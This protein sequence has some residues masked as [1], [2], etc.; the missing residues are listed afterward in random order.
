MNSILKKN[1]QFIV[2]S[3]LL[4]TLVFAAISPVATAQAKAKTDPL[5]FHDAMRKLWED[6]ITFTRLFIVSF[7]GGLPDQGATADRLLQNQVHIGNAI[8]PFY[9][10]AAGDQLTA[11]LRDHILI[12]VEVLDAA[13]NNPS[14]LQVALDRWYANADDIAVFLNGANPENWPLEEMRAM[15]RAHLDLTFREAAAQLGGQYAASIAA[16]DEVHLQALEMADMLS[17]GIIKQ[18][19]DKFKGG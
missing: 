15:L 1:V 10:D 9:G 13:K 19:P 3:L 8:K 16:Y 4:L 7:A 11:L 2:A 17:T 12:A 6:H 18:F 14:A 5:A